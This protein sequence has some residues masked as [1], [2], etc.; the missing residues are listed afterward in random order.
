MAYNTT[1]YLPQIGLGDHIGTDSPADLFESGAGIFQSTL[2]STF[3]LIY[4]QSTTPFL[5]VS[6]LNSPSVNYTA[7]Q[8]NSIMFCESPIDSSFCIDLKSFNSELAKVGIT[9]MPDQIQGQSI[10]S[11]GCIQY[12][13][14]KNADVIFILLFHFYL[15][16]LI[17]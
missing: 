2:L 12:C 16:Y 10:S 4:I 1:L 9:L 11:Y 6:S 7:D 13:K 17:R 15:R 3:D 14:T 8:P 5:N